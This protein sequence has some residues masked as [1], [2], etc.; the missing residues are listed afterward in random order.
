MDDNVG[1]KGAH[2]PHTIV[3]MG[4]AG[5]GK[6]T[7]GREL[8]RSLGGAFVDADDHHTDENR[9]KMNA[10]IA[11]DDADRAPWLDTLADIVHSPDEERPLVLACSALKTSYRARIARGST[12]VH[13]VLLDVPREELARRLSQRKEHFVGEKLL[14]SQLATW[15]P[16]AKD[17]IWKESRVEASG[18]R[19]EV[20]ARLLRVLNE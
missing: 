19:T 4:P 5:S 10:G 14:E 12:R 6:T 13:F 16:L 17:S 18:T 3:L 2:Q 1:S 8:A 11:L 20:L 9:R 7:M 15:E